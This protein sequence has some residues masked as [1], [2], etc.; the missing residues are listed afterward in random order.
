M[1]SPD[2]GYLTAVQ[3]PLTSDTWTDGGISAGELTLDPYLD[4]YGLHWE[5]K[6]VIGLDVPDRP[7]F[8]TLGQF[9]PITAKSY[10]LIF[11]A[12]FD[13]LPSDTWQHLSIAFGHADDRYYEHRSANSDGYHALVRADG[14]MAI[15]AHVHGDRQRRGP[16]CQ[17]AEHALQTG[18]L[19]APYPRRHSDVRSA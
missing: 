1:I 7:A 16:H 17:P 12:T 6:G 10:R 13:P 5:E 2:L 18:A 19:D 15:Y 9:C 4:Q 14:R 8:L 3:P 11:D